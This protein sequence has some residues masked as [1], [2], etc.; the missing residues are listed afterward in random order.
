MTSDQL[1][2]IVLNTFS[3]Q[4]SPWLP[5]WR[6]GTRRGSVQNQDDIS[7]KSGTT[8]LGPASILKF[9]VQKTWRPQLKRGVF[10]YVFC[11]ENSSPMAGTLYLSPPTE[12]RGGTWG[13]LCFCLPVGAAFSLSIFTQ[14]ELSLQA[15]LPQESLVGD[16]T[17]CASECNC[18]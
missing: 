2:G 4:N 18:I 9:S 17:S 11:L 6:Q 7:S 1:L 10:G 12:K 13:P 14:P 15:A 3:S 5:V 8:A 16:L